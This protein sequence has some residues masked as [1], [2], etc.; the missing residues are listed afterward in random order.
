MY[1]ILTK[2]KTEV[3]PKLSSEFAY[4]NVH[5]IPKLVK[6]VLN[7]GV[8]DAV[9][10]NKLIE[11]ATNDLSLIAGQ[12]AV[13]RKAKKSIANF[14]LRAGQPVGV[15][16]TLRRGRMYEFVDRLLNIALPRV[17]DFR[18]IARNAFDGNGNYSMGIMEQIIFPEVDSEKTQIR[19]LNITFVTSAKTNKE[20]EALL[21]HLG[22]PFRH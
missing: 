4:K 14:K 20:G 12:K 3:I 1:R 15:S 5:E 8:G 13:P 16:V 17:R 9:T 11:Q 19:G 7:M 21:A 10:N 6:V 2:Y 18:G 22:F